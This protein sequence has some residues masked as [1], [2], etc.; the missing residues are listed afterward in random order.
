MATLHIIQGFLGAGKSTFS[1][2]LATQT[3]ALHLN[4]D[5]WCM[6]L[7]KPEEYESQ[8]E[9]CFAQT[10]EILWQK[11]EEALKSGQDVIFDCGFWNRES[12]DF[13]KSQAQKFGADYKHYY[14]Y[15]PDK[16]LKQRIAQRTGKI[17]EHNLAHFDEIKLLFAEPQEDEDAILIKNYT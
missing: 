11:T 2:Q 7:F 16:I 12:R 6:R 9:K 8:W 4:P 3:N 13:A 14:I 10:L 5:D 17:A 1:R 15:A